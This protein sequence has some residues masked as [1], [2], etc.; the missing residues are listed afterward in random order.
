MVQIAIQESIFMRDFYSI[1]L[2]DYKKRNTPNFT[3]CNQSQVF[4]LFWE[5]PDL[6]EI[7]QKDARC[8]ISDNSIENFSVGS[9]YLF[10][11]VTPNTNNEDRIK[12]REDFLIWINLYYRDNIIL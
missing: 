10:I 9:N 3:L 8:F 6:K 5:N 1:V 11:S 12:I 2:D 7:I 4:A